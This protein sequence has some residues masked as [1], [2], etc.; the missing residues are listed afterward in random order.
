M[1]Y[2][3]LSSLFGD[4][5]HIVIP[6]VVV[7]LDH[8]D[9]AHVFDRCVH[10]SGDILDLKEGLIRHVTLQQVGTAIKERWEVEGGSLEQGTQ[11]ALEV[12]REGVAIAD[13]LFGQ[14]VDAR[15]KGPDGDLV[16][17]ADY[18][19]QEHVKT[20]L[21]TRY[22]GIQ[23]VGE[24]GPQTVAEGLH[25]V[26]DPLDGTNNFAIGIPCYAVAI[27]IMSDRQP[28]A[29]SVVQG[30][31]GRGFTASVSTGIH[32]DGPPW[33][34]L[35]NSGSALRASLWLGYGGDGAH[36]G[37]RA[38]RE[39]LYGRFSRVLESWSP[40]SDLFAILNGSLNLVVGMNCSGM[41]I[42]AA[43]ATF[44]T[45]GWQTLTPDGGP[46]GDVAPQLDFIA[47]EASLVSSFIT[48]LD[49]IEIFRD[50]TDK[51]WVP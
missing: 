3:Q 43:I 49:G 39:A 16:T 2:Q 27:S 33:S 22:P 32:I 36:R 30:Q 20:R 41:E 31:T 14:H 28:V 12:A 46:L 42:P 8:R 10:H 11:F 21:M 38:M 19:V 50:R 45:L 4:A 25:F 17:H 5:L 9:E 15:E 26:V 51:D 29:A 37:T 1:H 35:T 34:P 40:A 24:E 7:Q 23:V 48:A 44:R 13:G 47:G 6:I 18:I